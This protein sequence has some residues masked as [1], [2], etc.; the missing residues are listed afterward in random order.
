M[1]TKYDFFHSSVAQAPQL[2][3]LSMKFAKRLVFLAMPAVWLAEEIVERL[4]Y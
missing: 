2:H 1:E 4:S 3:Q